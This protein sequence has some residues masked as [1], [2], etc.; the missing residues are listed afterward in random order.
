M[1]SHVTDADFISSVGMACPLEQ[2]T[3]FEP[4]S[5][6]QLEDSVKTACK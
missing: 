2:L 4:D 5:A 1:V 3:P 6:S